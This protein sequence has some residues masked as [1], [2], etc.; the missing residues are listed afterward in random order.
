MNI[1]ALK[2]N[3]KEGMV[4]YSVDQEFTTLEEFTTKKEAKAFIAR[5]KKT[6]KEY[7]E[8]IEYTLVKK[9]IVNIKRV[10][11]YMISYKSIIIEEEV[12]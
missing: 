7:G 1:R 10:N 2:T 5:I 8:E 6:D 4:V 3:I 12:F 9:K 11:D